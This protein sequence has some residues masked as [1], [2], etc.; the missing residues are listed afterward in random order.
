MSIASDL[1]ALGA[2]LKNNLEAKGVTGL[3]SNMGL[4]TLANKILNISPGGGGIKLQLYYEYP[5]GW[6][7]KLTKDGVGVSDANIIVHEYS[8]VAP[9]NYD[10]S[11]TIISTDQNGEI[12]L[13]NMPGVVK[14]I[15]EYN[16]VFSNIVDINAAIACYGSVSDL[17]ISA[18]DAAVGKGDTLSIQA[19]VIDSNGNGLIGDVVTFC[20]S[21]NNNVFD[22][23]E[24]VTDNYGNAVC[25][26]V[27]QNR[28]EVTVIVECM[29]LQ[30]TYVVE[31]VSYYFPNTYHDEIVQLASN[32]STNFK[33]EYKIKATQ[34]TY[35][36]HYLQVG[37]QNNAYMIGTISPPADKMQIWA[38]Q[39]SGP[40]ASIAG[41]LQLDTWHT[42]T[43][44]YIEGVW[45]VTIDGQTIQLNYEYTV[46]DVIAVRPEK[47]G[48]IKEIKIT[49]L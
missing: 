8:E 45:T 17:N 32:I 44:S 12:N 20:F 37:A 13:A 16:G 34:N 11:S 4:T 26:Y 24:I 10:Y 3:N 48:Y 2:T 41:S 7:G 33:V 35:H 22:T 43:V 14:Y 36:G 25:E 49:E 15:L 5:D 38:W 9:D 29:S 19:S 40:S 28:G 27:G 21:Q 1:A 18:A 31:D 42:V 47:Y 30:E 46:R 6:I 39:M 23:F